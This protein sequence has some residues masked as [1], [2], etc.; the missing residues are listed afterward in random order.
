MITPSGIYSFVFSGTLA[1]HAVEQSLPQ[2]TNNEALDIERIAKKMPLDF[3]DKQE[4]SAAKKMASVYTAIC[5]FENSARKFIQDRLIETEGANWWTSAVPT[6]VRNE[7]ETRKKQEEQIRWHGKRGSSMIF[8]TQLGD[9]V[10]ILRNNSKAFEN[11]IES[12]DWA[13][14]IFSSLE[15]SRNV[16]MHSGELSMNDIERV[17]MNI[18]DWIRQVGG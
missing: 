8:F 2:S 12:I 14:Q 10:K 16:I 7:A 18:R 6:S 5:A 4:V 15:R 9:L 11:H 3:L 1:Q 17:S 13:Q